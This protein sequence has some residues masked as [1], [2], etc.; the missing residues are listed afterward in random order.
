MELQISPKRVQVHS[1]FR[2]KKFIDP[3]ASKFLSEENLKK[4]CANT[5]NTE[6]TKG[7]NFEVQKDKLSNEEIKARIERRITKSMTNKMLM[8][9]NS[10][11]AIAAI[12]NLII[13][14]MAKL[15]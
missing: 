4:E 13:P 1:A 6:L 14:E 15:K 8:K 11:Q 9:E 10:S 2:L 7:Q 3:N 5:Q 12:N